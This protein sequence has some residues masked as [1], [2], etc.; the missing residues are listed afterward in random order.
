MGVLYKGHDLR[1]DFRKKKYQKMTV[2]AQIN[3][4]ELILEKLDLTGHIP[5]LLLDNS[6][7]T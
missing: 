5:L 1:N 4:E 2:E 7:V 3:S 6:F